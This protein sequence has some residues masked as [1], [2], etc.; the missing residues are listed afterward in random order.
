MSFSVSRAQCRYNDDTEI[1]Y[2]MNVC[3]N[4]CVCLSIYFSEFNLNVITYMYE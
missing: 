4:A 3:V 1:M 2:F